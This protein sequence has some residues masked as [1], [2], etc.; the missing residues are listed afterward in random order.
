[1]RHPGLSAPK[2]GNAFRWRRSIPHRSDNAFSDAYHSFAAQSCA[3]SA[4]WDS[5]FSSHAKEQHADAGKIDNPGRPESLEISRGPKV[6]EGRRPAAV[7]YTFASSFPHAFTQCRIDNQLP[8]RLCEI[9]Q[10]L[11]F[12]DE[13]ILVVL[14]QF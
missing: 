11:R 12:G 6:A 2:P 9:I 5:E 8:D 13:A 1:D 10:I 7:D 3:G 14:D 4:R